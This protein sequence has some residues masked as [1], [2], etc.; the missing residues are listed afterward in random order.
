[1]QIF[2]PFGKRMQNRSNFF[3]WLV[4]QQRIL[5][6]ENLLKRHWPVTGFATFV[7]VLLKTQTIWQRTALSQLQYGAKFAS[8]RDTT[9]LHNS[10][11]QIT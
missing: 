7:E 8:G 5:T 3:E 10:H 9:D 6:A 1:M 2:Y 4:L 11:L